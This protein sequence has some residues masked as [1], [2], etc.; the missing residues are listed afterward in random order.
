MKICM[1]GD[2]RAENSN[3]DV[4]FTY[5]EYVAPRHDVTKPKYGQKGSNFIIPEI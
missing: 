3:M 4:T 5:L 1:Q 2:F